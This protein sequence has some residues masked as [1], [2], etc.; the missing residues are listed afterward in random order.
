MSLNR[1]EQQVFDYV[2][3]HADERHYWLAK[4]QTIAAAWPDIHVAA[5]RLEPELWRYYQE[6]SA[7]VP[8][9]R[10]AVRREGSQRTSMKIL[11]EHLLRLWVA[12][13]PKPPA[14]PPLPA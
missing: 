10:E 3:R 9:F 5:R 4:V 8:A 2:Q 11:A 12:P 14:A 13:R 1:S 7:V 6:R